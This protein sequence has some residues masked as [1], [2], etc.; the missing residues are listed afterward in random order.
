MIRKLTSNDHD[1]ISPFLQKEP[2]IN[3]FIIGDIENFGYDADFQELWAEFD[4]ENSVKAVM[5]RYHDSFI[6]Y[7]IKGYNAQGFVEISKEYK[8][9]MFCGSGGIL[10]EI[11]PF[12]PMDKM[13]R[14]DMYF[15]ECTA[16]SVKTAVDNDLSSD[17]INYV[18][19][20][21]ISDV[22][23]L[24]EA[25]KKIEEFASFGSP[26]E[27]LVQRFER[28]IKSQTGRTYYIEK[29]GM[30]I[31]GASTSAENSMSAMIVGVFT[32]PEYRGEGYATIILKKMLSDMLETKKTLCLFYDNPKAG[33]I[34]KRCGFY[35][36]GQWRIYRAEN[37]L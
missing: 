19:V 12:L 23:R 5:L 11:E 33:D 7:G 13:V 36:I 27:E 10:D 2:S 30:I 34:Y 14:R 8:D 31:S 3:L 28:N 25:Q 1:V 37:E 26:F 9:F 17:L 4:N 18:K 29:D 21:E 35:D 32:L 20:A 24:V 6:V 16:D 15:S 22:R